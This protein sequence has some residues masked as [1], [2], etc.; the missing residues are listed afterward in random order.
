M[1]SV[2]V[3][4]AVVLMTYLGYVALRRYPTDGRGRRR[5]DRPDPSGPGPLPRLHVIMP[6]RLLDPTPGHAGASQQ[7][8]F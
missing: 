3:F 7:E 6:G 1:R 4:T 8:R 5:R 2:L